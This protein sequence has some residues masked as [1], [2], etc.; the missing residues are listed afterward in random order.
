MNTLTIKLKQHTPLIHFQHDQDGATLRASEVKPKLD[1]YIIKHEFHDNFD[2]CKKYLV[3]YNPKKLKELKSK[4]DAGIRA[5]DY[6]MSIEASGR[7]EY[8]IG[9]IVGSSEPD[10][11]PKEVIILTTTPFFAQEQENRKIV[12]T[13][14]EGDKKVS[15]FHENEWVKIP[16]KGL[17]WSDVTLEMFSIRPSLIEII[18]NH[19]VCFFI[20]TNFGT[21]S[22][23]GFGS[24]TVESVNGSSED[25]NFKEEIYEKAFKT[26]YAFC[27]KR[28]FSLEED[29]SLSTIFREI[30]SDYQKLKSGVNMG[31]YYKKSL[32]FCYAIDRMN[33]NPRWEKRHFK[34]EMKDQLG[35]TTTLDQ[36]GNKVYDVKRE[37]KIN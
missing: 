30:K 34:Q 24:F 32:L 25:S 13:R 18:R 1:K 36:Q 4:W 19:V 8:M 23:K 12:T 14:K 35:F 3:G 22:D 6:K 21:R 9:S 15:T 33:Q 11:K 2:E 20:C 16:K 28:D 10:G 29:Y 17:K 37:L 7:E 31:K 26:N 5:L 27:Y